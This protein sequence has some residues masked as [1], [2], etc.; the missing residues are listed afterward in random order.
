MLFEGI[1]LTHVVL[2]LI[3]LTAILIKLRNIEEAEE[4]AN[5]KQTE[6][7]L[8]YLQNHE[9]IDPMIALNELG[10]MR[11]AARISDLKAAGIQIDGITRYNPTSGK[12][13]KEYRLR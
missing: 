7:V 11:L 5:M 12:H 8:V 2:S 1:V 4:M 6:M 9:Y 3:I 13:W 10:V